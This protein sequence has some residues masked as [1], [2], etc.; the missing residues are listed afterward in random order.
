MGICTVRP[1]QSSGFKFWSAHC[2]NMSAGPVGAMP[3]RLPAWSR[4]P[5]LL[6]VSYITVVGGSDQSGKS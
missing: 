6:D 4:F 2:A 1:A 5:L 3:A